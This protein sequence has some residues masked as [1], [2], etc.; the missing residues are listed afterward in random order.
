[1]L[2]E[3][4]TAILRA[5]VQEYIETAQPVGS[6]HIASAP[7]VR[8]SPATVRNEM[9]V[10]EQEGYLVQP[11]T[12][13]GRIPTDKG[14]RFF[15]DHL[16]APGP[17]D[18]V[19][20]QQ[21][22]EFFSG[23]R[24]AIEGLLSRTGQLLNSL[25][26]YASVVVGPAQ[27]LGT[28]RTVQV[29]ALGAKHAVVVVV[30]SNGTVANEP[31]ELDHEMSDVKLA[32]AGA[33]LSR[34]LVGEVLTQ[35]RVVPLTDDA[36]VDRICAA[37]LGVLS[38]HMAESGSPVFVRGASAMASAFDAVATVREVLAALEQQYVVVS[39]VH[40]VL[41]RGLSVAIGAEHGVEPLVSCAVVLA[42]VMA[43][44]EQVGTVGV[45]GPTRMNYPHA[46]ASVAVVSERLG[47]RLEDS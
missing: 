5:V 17:L 38:V 23:A 18:E 30:L 47:R 41:D 12:S 16:T 21:V 14:Y 37:V 42:P 9:S 22:G 43:D 15:V 3:R 35:D 25:T 28:V 45:V 44:G 6:G 11:H 39:L 8:V 7:G 24:G 4:K 26:S 31:L 1:M 32:A 46:L 2:D 27:D 33:H 36:V 29:V 10:L 13:A 40:D 34:F 20:H 19:R